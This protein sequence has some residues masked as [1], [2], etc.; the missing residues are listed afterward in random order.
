[1]SRIA[2]AVAAWALLGSGMLFAQSTNAPSDDPLAG[3]NLDGSDKAVSVPETFLGKF[4]GHLVVLNGNHAKPAN[5]ALLDGVKFVA[6]YYSA[7]WCA[8]CRAFTPQLVEFYNS[9]KATHPNFEL[10]F[11]DRDSDTDSMLDYMSGD[12]MPWPAVRFDDINSRKLRATQFMGTGIPCLVLVDDTGRVLSD[13]F[14]N[15]E[16]VGPSVVMDAI[17]QKVPQS[18]TDATAPTSSAP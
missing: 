5:P 9:F 12:K 18:T 10:I 2:A 6:F 16:Y 14:V 8:P 13:S 15:G 11:V 1:M 3:L 17:R 7:S 4:S